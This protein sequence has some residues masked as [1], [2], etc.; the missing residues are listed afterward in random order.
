MIVKT[1]V[2]DKNNKNIKIIIANINKKLIT[3]VTMFFVILNSL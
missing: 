3:M 1:M 2:N